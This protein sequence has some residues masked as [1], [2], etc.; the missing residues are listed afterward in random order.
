MDPHST[1]KKARDCGNC[2]NL[3]KSIGLGYGN[4]YIKNGKW[5]FE[6]ATSARPSVFGSDRLD[7]FVNIDGKPLVHTSRP[8]L[9]TF[10]KQEINKILNV[11]ICLSCHNPKNEKIF[12]NI[13]SKVQP[14]NCKGVKNLSIFTTK[15]GSSPTP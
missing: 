5:Q 14:F 6:P 1:S 15:K 9:R 8:S 7:A 2:H 12:Q 11:G 3:S 10:N 4:L 13:Q